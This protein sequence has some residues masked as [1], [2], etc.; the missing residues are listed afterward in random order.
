MLEILTPLGTKLV[1]YLTEISTAVVAC[2][3]VVFGSD[4]NR[5][6]RRVLAGHHF[7]IRTFAFILINAFGFGLFIVKVSPMLS[8]WLKQIDRSWLVL[9][10]LLW[11]TLVGI[12]AQRN[13][14]V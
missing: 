7:I 14:Q 13:R 3:L 8:D 11:F 9:G 6:L 1:P 4:I 10:L 5:T 12:W 2:G